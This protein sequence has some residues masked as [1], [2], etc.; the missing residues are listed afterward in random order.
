MIDAAVPDPIGRW[1]VSDLV[2]R[3][4]GDHTGSSDGAATVAE[5]RDRLVAVLARWRASEP[6]IRAAASEAPFV[7]EGLPAA[8]ALART[9]A[10]ALEALDYIGTGQRAP[11]GWA[12]PL[13]A[14]LTDL[15][16]P[17]ELLRLMIVPSVRRLVNAAALNS[18]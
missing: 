3:V 18:H 7:L 12:D 10:I 8:E 9:C 15:E 11:Q 5:A 17:K 13:L 1:E 4:L 16:Q 2:S 14:E 6:V